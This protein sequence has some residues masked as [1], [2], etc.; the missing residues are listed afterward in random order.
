MILPLDAEPHALI[1]K[2]IN[3]K[4]KTPKP[5]TKIKT[6]QNLNHQRCITMWRESMR[7]TGQAARKFCENR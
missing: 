1:P 6:P 5:K 3:L 4:P 2:P 7:G